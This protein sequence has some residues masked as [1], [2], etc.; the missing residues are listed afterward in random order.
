MLTVR[1]FL[2]EKVIVI[3]DD[4]TG[5]NEIAAIMMKKEK[6]PLVLNNIVKND[7]I[8]KLWKRY[9]GLVFNLNSRNLPGQKAY[10]KIKN[11]LLSS[12]E[13]KRRLIYKK[14]D[15]TLR[16]N[17][18]KEI[19]AVLDVECADIVVLVPALPRMGRVTVGGYHLV[20]QV[21]VGRTSYAEDFTE[22][23]LP[24]LLR[25]Q[26]K[27]QVG[28]VGLQTVQSGVDVISQQLIGEYEKESSIVVCDCCTQ[29]DLKSIKHAI[30]NLNLKVLPVG[31]AGLFEEL[32]YE[33]EPRSLPCL[34]ICGSLN[35]I[36]RIQLIKL[37]NEE[38][39]GYLELDLPSVLSKGEQDELK[40]LV[41]EGETILNQGKNL[42]IATSGKRWEV[43][44]EGERDM[45]KLKINQSLAY[46]AKHFIKR[47]PLVG[48]IAT[49]GDT[50][51]ALLDSLQAQGI[52]VVDELEPLVP[53]GIIRGWLL[54]LKQVDLV[55]KMCF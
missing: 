5:A 30:L 38:R 2:E 25:T 10:N 44:E 33:D 7:V 14:I 54:S 8:R 22:S 37:I 6:V 41:L 53:A 19:D 34:I 52:E 40:R 47:Y 27:Y 28:Y 4:L 1:N 15:S 46:L 21:P 51:K 17:V 36:T 35:R 32:F 50:A 42:V 55:E 31:S 49:G 12:E 16:G 3:A 23:F 26:S 18:G 39:T 24:E 9:D 45:I 20:K 29:D 48:V 11:F 13:I 43:K